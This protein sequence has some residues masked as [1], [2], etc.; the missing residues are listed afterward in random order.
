MR[1][2]FIVF[3]SFSFAFT[4]TG[5]YNIAP[6]NQPATTTLSGEQQD[7]APDVKKFLETDWQAPLTDEMRDELLDESSKYI[8]SEP[9]FG[10]NIEYKDM[11]LT[12]ESSAVEGTDA[13]TL[14]DQNWPVWSVWPW[15]DDSHLRKD[16]SALPV[17][18]NMN[19]HYL[20]KKSYSTLTFDILFTK[21]TSGNVYIW[22]WL[23][24][25]QDTYT[26][27]LTV[28]FD[29]SQFAGSQFVVGASGFKGAL[30]VPSSIISPGYVRHTIDI[31]INFGGYKDRGWRLEFCWM[32]LGNNANGYEQTPPQETTSPYYTQDLEE[33]VPQSGTTDVVV[34]YKVICG[35]NTK[36]NI[37]TENVN[38]A[39]SRVVD[40]YIDNV[41]KGTI[42]SPGAYE[43]TL[44]EYAPGSQQCIL[45]FVFKNMPDIYKSKRITQLAVHRIGF[46]LEIDTMEGCSQATLITRMNAMNAWLVLHGYHRITYYFS[47]ILGF[48]EETTP[49][50]HRGCWFWFYEHKFISFWE[51][52]IYVNKLIYDGEYDAGWHFADFLFDYGIGI[53]EI[54]S[55]TTT[56]W[57]EYGHHIGIYE[58][59]QQGKENY[60]WN[61]RCVMSTSGAYYYCWFHWHLRSWF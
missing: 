58:E 53:S 10:E 34:E 19:G 1:I 39:Y 48:A 20:L 28:K 8:W 43:L 49:A 32:G 40:I 15:Q 17:A 33:L 56:I 4:S 35:T 61:S 52:V 23:V 50:D 2:L 21:P 27:T 12:S 59:N 16:F 45:K 42:S 46:N 37:E 29:G 25:D 22:I 44:G 41:K 3:L 57:H 9:M 5:V 14:G 13:I 30:L 36:L 60:C 18:P 47:G 6:M 7:L 51:Y 11:N 24:R 38:D 54:D 31:S 55:K 26:R